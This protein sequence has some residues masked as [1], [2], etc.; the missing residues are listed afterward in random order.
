MLAISRPQPGFPPREGLASDI[1][2][3]D[4]KTANHFLQWTACIPEVFAREVKKLDEGK[5]S[6]L[7]C[8]KQ[9]ESSI[10]SYNNTGYAAHCTVS[11]I[12]CTESRIC[13]TC[14]ES[15]IGCTESKIG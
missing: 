10:Y 4:G 7:F 5:K 14:T 9:A 2:V 15:R 3:G 13:F 12:C 6:S 8:M 1:P 11:R